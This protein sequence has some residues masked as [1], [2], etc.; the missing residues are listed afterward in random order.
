VKEF[1]SFFIPILLGGI[2]GILVEFAVE[3]SSRLL[4]IIA[5]LIGML[6]IVISFYL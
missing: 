4:A 2:A 5:V 6:S 1:I 3:I